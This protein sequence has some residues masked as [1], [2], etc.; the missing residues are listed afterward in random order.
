[1][2]VCVPAIILV[3]NW[4]GKMKLRGAPSSGSL[5]PLLLVQFRIMSGVEGKSWAEEPSLDMRVE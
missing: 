1:M 3:I 4:W 2:Y 5:V